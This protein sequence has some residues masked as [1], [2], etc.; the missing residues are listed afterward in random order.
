MGL[1]DKFKSLVLSERKLDIDARFDLLR[2]AISGTM[3]KFYM[4]KDRQSGNVIGLKLCDA[5]KLSQFEA[6]FKGLNKPPEGAIAISL[7]HP[8]VVETL[9]HGTTSRGLRYI[10]MEFLEGP[11]L[12]T[13]T[14]SR[15]TILQGKRLSLIRQM[16]ESLEYVHS[17]GF[18]HRDICPRN[19]ICSPD[20]E[21]LKLIDFVLTVPAERGFM[22]PGNRTGTAAYMAPEVVRRRTTDPRLDVF[23]FGM[24]AY[25]LCAYELPWPVGENPALSAMAHDSTPPEDIFKYCPQLNKV[26]AEAIIQCL[27]ADPS[28]RPQT[29]GDFLYLIRDVEH[30]NAG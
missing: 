24:T 2:E 15:D 3:S 14:Q 17:S 26:L 25:H 21:S 4:A 6:R 13:L 1:F 29:L 30:E 9:E 11:G 8:R 5:E 7:K 28:E 22:Q 19:F 16:A 18:I 10:V 20:A 12:H 23:S 27:A